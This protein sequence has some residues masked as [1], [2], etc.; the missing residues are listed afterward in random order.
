M[1]FGSGHGQAAHAVADE[2][3]QQAPDAEVRVVDALDTSR[4]W[5]RA[6]YV[7]PYW[8]MVRYAPALWRRLFASRLRGLTRH[9]APM[10]VLRSGCRPTFELVSTWQPDVIVAAEVGACELATCAK[11]QA[12]PH[13]HLVAV[14]TDHLAEP[15]WVSPHVDT[16]AVADEGV[17]EQL[18]RWGAPRERIHVTG[19]P[20]RAAFRRDGLRDAVQPAHADPRQPPMVLMMGG[21]M[22]PSRM[23]RI[24]AALGRSGEPMHVVAVAGRDRAAYRRLVR[25]PESRTTSLTVH[26]WTDDIP[27]LMSSA[28]VLVTKPGG[29]TLAEAALCGTPSVLFDPIPGPEECNAAW[30]VQGGMA[31]LTRGADA[32]ANTVLALVR[33]EQGRR[34][35]ASAAHAVGTPAAAG[36]VAALAIDGFARAATRRPVLVLSIRN[37][38]GHTRAAAAIA[39]RLTMNGSTDVSMVD[40]ADY[41]SPLARLTHVSVYLWLVRHAPRIWER[42]DRFQQQR[43]HTSPEWYYRRG[44]RRLFEYVR[45]REP[46]AL[47]A[48]E[49]GCCEIAALIKRDLGLLIPLV[50]VNGEYDADRAWVQPE[51]DV[52]SVAD[53]TVARQLCALGA[54]RE[55]VRVW[56]VPLGVQF[57]TPVCRDTARTAL[58]RRLRFDPELPIVLVSGGSEGLGRPDLVAARLLRLASV[59][60]QAVVLA[61]RSRHVVRRCGAIPISFTSRLRVLGWTDDVHELMDAADLLVSKLGHTFDEAVA[62]GLPIV[63]L[64]PPPGAERVQYRFLEAWGI[65]R[66][67][68]DLND[69]SA[70]VERL[71]TNPPE[72]ASL[73]QAALGRRQTDAAAE[74]ARWIGDATS[75]PAVRRTPI[76]VNPSQRPVLVASEGPP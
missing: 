14:I 49:V 70:T 53:S 41:M 34:A 32:T 44:C 16:Y 50:A 28:S 76:A 33:D 22:G 55:Q 20:T 59:R 74:I 46:L 60:V 36:N 57:S 65:G 38:A 30:A 63:A 73:R 4:M 42:I 43:R 37:G 15:A 6:I 54:A 10:P 56:G 2:L 51:V 19:I 67:V 61:G 27:T 13:A 5:F 48:T 3:A 45:S 9:T 40:V 47:V 18:Y 72:L 31:V 39:E 58:S 17:R 71:L 23:D 35:L 26:R 24:V 7:W 25:L 75:S 29:S 64:Q 62:R 66:A 68:R 12:F 21:G 1:A 69:M 8:G 52:Y 11:Q